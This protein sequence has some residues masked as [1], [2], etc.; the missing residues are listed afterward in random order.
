M[1]HHSSLRVWT[2]RLTGVKVE[3]DTVVDTKSVGALAPNLNLGDKI[4]EHKGQICAELGHFCIQRGLRIFPISPGS[5]E[6]S[7]N[8]RVGSI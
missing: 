4:G 3:P 1:T 6:G 8:R 2:N 7:I 5:V